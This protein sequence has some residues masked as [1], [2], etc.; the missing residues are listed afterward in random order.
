VREVDRAQHAEDQDEPDGDE[1][2]RRAR[3]Q[4]VGELLQDLEQN[5]RG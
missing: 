1:R 5:Q 3:Q 4:A 2:V